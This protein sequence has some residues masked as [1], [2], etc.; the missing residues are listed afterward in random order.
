MTTVALAIVL[1]AACH[2]GPIVDTSPEPPGTGGT[3][4][5]IVR[6]SAASAPLPGRKVTATNVSTGQRY[7]VSTATNGGY[8]LKVPEGRY[9]LDVELRQNE[10]LAAS[11]AE[12]EV[13][14]GDLDSA[15]DFTVTVAAQP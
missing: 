3:I 2:P 5:G 10:T 11:P 13:N 9:R 14:R 7:E 15:R 1:G 8:T 12:T 6:A 4:A